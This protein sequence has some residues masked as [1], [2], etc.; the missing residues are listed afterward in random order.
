MIICLVIG[1]DCTAVCICVFC[2]SFEND[3]KHD[4][5]PYFLGGYEGRL[6]CV[7][8][9]EDGETWQGSSCERTVG[10]NINQIGCWYCSQICSGVLGMIGC[11]TIS[12]SASNLMA[13]IFV[14]SIQHA[15]AHA[16][17]LVDI[18]A[19]CIKSCGL[20]SCI[21]Y[22]RIYTFLFSE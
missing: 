21:S 14:Y 19:S 18:Y 5:F 20:Q 8:L 15:F 4:M 2:L 1:F 7:H 9:P 22:P 17:V 3:G 12:S 16:H 10:G 11:H 13:H 6:R